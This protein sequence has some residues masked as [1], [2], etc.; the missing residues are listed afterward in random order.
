MDI[1][2]FQTADPVHYREMLEATS[3]T[4]IEFCRRHGH[5]YESYVGIKRGVHPWQATFNRMFQFREL[6][7]RGFAGWGVYLDADA[8]VNDLDFD[9]AGYLSARADRAA[10]LVPSSPQGEVWN[11][12]A[13]VALINLGHPLGRSLVDRWLAAYMALDDDWIRR[14]SHWPDD[15]NDQYMLYCILR[16]DPVLRDAIHFESPDL[17]NSDHARFIRQKLRVYMPDQKERTRALR[18][19]VDELLGSEGE[20]VTER[21]APILVTAAYRAVLRRDPDGEGMANFTAHVREAG[22]E[23][24]LHQMI[25]A[26]LES[27]EYQARFGRAG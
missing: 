25:A 6:M 21:V 5:S 3:R 19:L 27:P 14:T 15:A 4:A 17:I 18:L 22:L 9:L 13:G 12:N 24:G 8:F 16:D 11:I 10:V 2:L 20:S 23:R 26:M 7:D 1:V